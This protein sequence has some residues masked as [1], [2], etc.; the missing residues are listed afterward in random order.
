MRFCP[1]F[2]ISG[3]NQ[4]IKCAKHFSLFIQLMVDRY[5][6]HTFKSYTRYR[7]RTLE[8]QDNEKLKV[9]KSMRK[10]EEVTL[11]SFLCLS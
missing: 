1:Q 5:V 6:Y 9:V 7:Q 10:K 8:L 3:H 11:F 2:C 4:I